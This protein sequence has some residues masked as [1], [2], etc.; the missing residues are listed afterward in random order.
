MRS[1]VRHIVSKDLIRFWPLLTLWTAA[2]I[3]RVSLPVALADSLAVSNRGERIFAFLLILLL[4]ALLV[5]RVVAEDS[6][7]KEAAFWRKLPISGGQML[8]AKLLFI[9]GWTM[10][11]PVCIVTVAGLLQGF[12]ADETMRV[13]TAQLVVHGLVGGMFFMVSLLTQRVLASILGLWLFGTAAQLVSSAAGWDSRHHGL[14][15]EFVEVTRSMTPSLALSAHI[16]AWLL[17]LAACTVAALWI[18]RERRRW[19]AAVM[20][21]AAIIG[22]KTVA[23]VWPWDYLMWAP[24]LKNEVAK[25]DP[26][27]AADIKMIENLGRNSINGV[28]YR[29]LKATA[30]WSGLAPREVALVYRTE[31]SVIWT[32]GTKTSQVQDLAPFNKDHLNPGLM[33]LGVARP[34]VPIAQSL[35][36]ELALAR[37]REAEYAALGQGPAEW[38]GRISA[39]IGHMEPELRLPLQKRSY[40]NGAVRIAI[41]ETEFAAERLVLKLYESRPDIP[42]GKL[43]ATRLAQTMRN[44]TSSYALI[45]HGRG[46]AILTSGGGGGSGATD[47]FLSTKRSELHFNAAELGR[48]FDADAWHTWLSEAEL[49]RFR[50]IE[51]RRVAFDIRLPLSTAHTPPIN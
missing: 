41:T 15:N 9:I 20:L 33:T 19:P 30:N 7:L 24:P 1:T 43:A 4:N 28:V 48:P 14:G 42:A 32:D 39:M 35:L 34:R 45:N 29:D 49:V 40:Q 25:S 31:G 10:L 27:Y 5:V 3:L 26:R 37:L 47:G 44:S 16:I 46:E 11:L 23:S 50:F 21:C 51:H 12:T 8:R 2:L 6:P 18:Y 13:A 17:A 38:Q 22:A 36:A